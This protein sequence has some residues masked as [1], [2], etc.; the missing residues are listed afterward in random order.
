MDKIS[1]LF[2]DET[3]EWKLVASTNKTNGLHTRVIWCCSWTHDSKYFATGSREGKVVVWG[4]D[5]SE[6]DSTLGRW[7]P[8]QPSLELKGEC[9]LCVAL[10][11]RF[12]GG[13]RFLVAVGLESGCIHLYWWRPTGDESSWTLITTLGKK[14]PLCTVSDNALTKLGKIWLFEML[15]RNSGIGFAR[16]GYF[17]RLPAV[18]QSRQH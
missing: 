5:S 7:Q 9:V 17:F 16:L 4:T 15:F 12:V 11:P 10:A 2:S 6:P 18:R 1:E 13:G 3:S 14:Y 8:N